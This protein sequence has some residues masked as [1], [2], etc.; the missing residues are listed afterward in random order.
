MAPELKPICFVVMPFGK[1]PVPAKPPEAPDAIDFDALWQKALLPVIQ[2]LGYDPVRADQDTGSSIILE[3]LERLF[4]SDLVVAD[5]TI[6]N[7]NV[8]YE[9]GIRHASR[10]TGCVLIS[11]DW[12]RPLFDTAQMRRLTYRLPEGVVT[13]ATAA[14]IRDDLKRGAAALADG[15][16]PVFEHIPG[17][18]DPQRVDPARASSIRTQLEA[19]SAFQARITQARVTIDPARRNELASALRTEYGGSR[20]MSQA[21]ALEMVTMVRDCLGWTDMAAYIDSLPQGLRDLNVLQEQRCLAQ[22]KSGDHEIAIGGLEALIDLKGDS[23]ERQG[24][25][26]GR[27]KQLAEAARGKG[28]MR[29]YETLLDQAIDHYE[30]GMKLDLNDFYATSNLPFLYRQRGSPGDDH[31]ARVSSQLARLACERDAQNQWAKRTLLTLAF[32]D[33][34]VERARQCAREVRQQRAPAWQLETTIST[35]ER[36]VEQTKDPEKQTALAAVLADLKR[37]L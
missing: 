3:M 32:F 17:F 15:T 35:L 20:P 26:G 21:V 2:D 13:D 6:P 34:D 9:V 27:Y 18:P 23:S 37:Q 36:S 7:G 22:S 25:I 1:K 29:G 14:G 12:A 5:M 33:E 11:A 19:I 10:R 4:F 31:Q 24:L 30:R 16:S 28:D 8:Y